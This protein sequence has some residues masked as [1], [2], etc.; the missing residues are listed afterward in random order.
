MNIT[1]WTLTLDKRREHVSAVC[2]PSL[3]SSP[4]PSR[5]ATHF[6]AY[7]VS[8]AAPPFSRAAAVDKTSCT[9]LF[10]CK[11][12]PKNLREISINGRKNDADVS[13]WVC[14]K[15]EN[16]KRNT[17]SILTAGV[18]LWPQRGCEQIALFFKPAMMSAVK[19]PVTTALVSLELPTQPTMNRPA[20]EKKPIIYT[21]I[22]F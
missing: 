21:F 3:S 6:F 1:L 11:I 10:L 8:A 22:I 9:D 7:G 19:N 18:S 12:D 4:P 5:Q 13:L 2:T 15:S 17:T 16:T 20:A 14:S